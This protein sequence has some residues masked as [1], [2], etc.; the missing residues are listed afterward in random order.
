MFRMESVGSTYR[1]H[2]CC[3]LPGTLLG[4][5]VE[6]ES[7]WILEANS[8]W[9]GNLGSDPSDP[10]MGLCCYFAGSDLQTDVPLLKT[11][12]CPFSVHSAQEHIHW[13]GTSGLAKG[14]WPCLGKLES[15][16]DVS[17]PSA[18]GGKHRTQNRP[19]PTDA[20]LSLTQGS[21]GLQLPLLAVM[22]SCRIPARL[23]WGLLGAD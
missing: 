12:C 9:E 6:E 4:L 23:I 21:L 18:G 7:M 22:S 19:G 3:V 5:C 13:R 8:F 20:D 2:L 1:E 17:R 15:Y 11:Q 16:S 10:G 14:S